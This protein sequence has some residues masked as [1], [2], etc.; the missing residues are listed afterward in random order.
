M[1]HGCLAL[2]LVLTVSLIPAS[3][4]HAELMWNKDTGWVDP[5]TL[6]PYVPDQR[7]KI[8]TAMMI[9]GDYESAVK[10]FQ[11]IL[12][13]HPDSDLA[14][15]CYY[16]IG[17]SYFLAGKY[18]KAFDT[19]EALL[20][21][22]PGIRITGLIH[23]KEFEAGTAL[24]QEKPKAS[25]PI[26]ERFIEHNPQGPLAPD[27]Q[28]KI[29]DAY[30]LAEDFVSAED[31]YRAVLENHPR[32]AWAPYAMYRIPLS[33]LSLELRR[34]RDMGNLWKARNGFEEY[35]ANYPDGALADEAKKK[36]HEA[37]N[38][39]A[40]KEYHIA[41]FY[42][43]KKNPSS[44]MVYLKRITDRFPNTRWAEKSQGT[45]AFLEKINAVKK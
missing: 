28:V 34:D 31:A 15:P 1:K 13:E 19:Y 37:E 21:R 32:S 17:Q 36:I 38:L 4:A 18:K 26:F 23:Q 10:E 27:S 42:L 14:E 12:D 39:L 40:Q 43:R 33:K 8:A 7:Y 11:G 2:L 44:A 29:A 22:F 35:L 45:I 30:F 9:N 24:M 5:L 41:E 6:D 20:E 25:V 3:G 16:N